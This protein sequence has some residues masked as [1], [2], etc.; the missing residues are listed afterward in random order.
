MSQS[1]EKEAAW[2]KHLCFQTPTY[3]V[4]EVGGVKQKF[5]PVSVG[6][7]FELKRLGNDLVSALALMFANTD[8]DAKYIHKT[9]TTKDGDT[10]STITTDPISFET[11]QYRDDQ[12][13]RSWNKA[14]DAI[15]APENAEVV[16]KVIMDS[17]REVFPRC[18]IT[19]KFAD[20][21]K[22][23]EFINAMPLP[24]LGAFIKG[25]CMA[26]KDVLGPLAPKAKS[27]LGLAESKLRESLAPDQKPSEVPPASST[28]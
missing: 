27:I 22:P 25:V 26:N 1:Q 4:E 19:G 21:V 2:K 15:F 17:L 14:V 16:A 9:I 12:K 6:M 3:H 13:A 28:N 18:P 23:S 10:E 5:Y 24:L 8:K 7:V 11:M 20:D